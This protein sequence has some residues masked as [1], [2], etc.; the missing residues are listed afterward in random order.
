M[1][2]M[3]V[4]LR[5]DFLDGAS[6]GMNMYSK[7]EE[8]FDSKQRRSELQRSGNGNYVVTQVNFPGDLGHFCKV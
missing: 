1:K 4:E 2:C 6:G 7:F 3:D 5:T 8:T